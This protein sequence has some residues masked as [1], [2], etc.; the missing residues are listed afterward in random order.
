MYD[1]ANGSFMLD[2]GYGLGEVQEEF[3]YNNAEEKLRTLAI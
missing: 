3:I 2:D 1:D